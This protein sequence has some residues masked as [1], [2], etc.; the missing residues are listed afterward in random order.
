[1]R[2]ALPAL[3]LLAAGLLGCPRKEEAPPPAPEA[4]KPA[5]GE[6]SGVAPVYPSEVK[7]IPPGVRAL[8]EAL[9]RLPAERKAAC[10]D[11][12]PGIIV[13]DECIRN[14]TGALGQGGVAL[15]LP[16]VRTCTTAI[17]AQLEG[18][19]WVG[20]H[21]PP[22]PGACTGVVRSLREAGAPCRATLE[23]QA[24]LRCA[25]AGPTDPGTCRPA[26][27]VGALCN[28]AVDPLATYLRLDVDT[29]RAPCAGGFCDKNRCRAHVEEGAA[30]QASVQCGPGRRCAGGACVAGAEGEAGA[31]CTGADCAAGLRCV[32]NVCAAPRPEG[33]LC[34]RHAECAAGCVAG[35]CQKV[36]SPAELLRALPGMTPKPA[37]QAPGQ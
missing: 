13:T 19:E 37:L 15:D 32:D 20:P 28:T 33:A 18:C 34:K 30:C 3:T 27:A 6:A 35:R 7:E 26:P 21:Q 2:R 29:L 4:A 25:G 5:R 24:G 31:R 17:A 11:T 1:M 16:A 22:L 10:C 9:H 23:C 12:T 14:L 8:C 36:C